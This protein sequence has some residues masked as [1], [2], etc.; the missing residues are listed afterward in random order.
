LVQSILGCKYPE[1]ENDF[2]NRFAIDIL[3]NPDLSFSDE[4][5]NRRMK[6]PIPITWERLVS[7]K[8]NNAST[9]EEL[10]RN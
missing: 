8:G 2:K 4:K 5:A 7:L 3:T 10:I 9:W 1:N 6:I